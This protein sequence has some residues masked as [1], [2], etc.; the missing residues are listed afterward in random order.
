MGTSPIHEGATRHDE[1]LGS[2]RLS[3]TLVAG[4][5]GRFVAKKW[6]SFSLRAAPFLRNKLSVLT[7]RNSLA[8]PHEVVVKSEAAV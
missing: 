2:G 6:Y 5:L 7:L 3:E 1:E 4:L 8:M